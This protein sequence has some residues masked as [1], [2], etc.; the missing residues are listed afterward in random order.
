MTDEFDS[1]A[2]DVRITSFDGMLLLLRPTAFME[3]VPTTFG[4]SDAVEADMIVLDGRGA[5]ETY[6]GVRIFQRMMINQLRSKVGSGRMVL[7]RLGLGPAKQGQSPP[8]LLLDPT[9]D[10]QK[11]ARAYLA[12]A[13][14]VNHDEPPF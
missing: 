10:D 8:W 9:E 7:G 11:L 2:S 3:A 5:G 4:P 1:P 13:A 12:K 14:A 6:T